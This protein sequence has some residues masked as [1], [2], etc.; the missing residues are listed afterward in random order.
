MESEFPMLQDNQGGVDATVVASLLLEV[1]QVLRKILLRLDSLRDVTMQ[2][3]N[4]LQPT[5]ALLRDTATTKHNSPWHREFM[6]VPLNIYK[7]LILF[8]P[9][10]YY[11]FSACCFV[12]QCPWKSRRMPCMAKFCIPFF[13]KKS[14]ISLSRSASL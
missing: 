4:L 1:G 9:V 7:A 13:E 2:T 11:V 10:S 3:G 14:F 12:V 8:N 6:H 5:I